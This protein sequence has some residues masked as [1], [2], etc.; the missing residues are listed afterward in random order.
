MTDAMRKTIAW[1][2]FGLA[3]LGLIGA[4]VI[5]LSSQA[6]N[7]LYFL[8][9]SLVIGVVGLLVLTGHIISNI[10]VNKE[11]LTIVNNPLSVS[12][13]QPLVT[14]VQREERKAQFIDT[15]PPGMI[16]GI[17]PFAV[18]DD[19]AAIRPMPGADPTVPIYRLDREFRILDWNEA[20]S[21]AF[22]GTL[23]GRRGQNAQEWV[24][25][26]DNYEE[27]MAHGVEK[28]GDAQHLPR[29]DQETLKYTSS[30]FGKLEAGKRAYQVPAADGSVDSWLCVLDLKFQSPDDGLKFQLELIS[31]IRNDLLWSEYAVFYDRVL[32]TSAVYGE[33]LSE[34][35]GE[36]AI[37]NS[38]EP[39][40]DDARVLDLGAGTGNIAF[41]LIDDSPRRSVVAVEKNR[42]MLGAL[43]LKCQAHLRTSRGEPGVLALKQDITNLYGLPDDCFDIA[44]LNNVLYS[45]NAPK[46]CLR[47]VLRVLKPGGEI[48]VS[49][50]KRDTDLTIL[51]ARIKKDIEDAGRWQE[52]AGDFTRMEE[53]NRYRLKDWLFRWTPSEVEALLKDCGFVGD[54]QGRIWLKTDAYA[55]QAM[56]LRAFKP[57]MP[58]A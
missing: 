21:L 40:A 43:R 52:L 35:L 48:R 4:F 15:P 25:F 22:D 19:P 50:P 18:L 51:F 39:I 23:E 38:L 41:R 16:G 42:F 8:F 17:K 53:I 34:I 49:G 1:T 45:L 7:T 13:P 57:L 12:A 31:V 36:T 2:F 55:G 20:F 11:G 46:E 28:F 5:A 6:Q 47:E 3:A 24:F 10:T 44:I 9:F 29:Y 32:N 27:V 33:L 56:I 58:P 30:R 37:A 14:E 26:L 54:M